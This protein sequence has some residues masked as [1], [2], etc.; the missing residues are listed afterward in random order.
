MAKLAMLKPMVA[1]L[2]T[3]IARPLP[4]QT[5][6]HYGTPEHK[7]WAADVIKR[8]GGVCRD[9]EHRGPRDGLRVVAD[10]VIER[11]D[12]PARQLDVSNGLTRCWACHTR[13]TA[14]ARAERAAAPTTARGGGASKV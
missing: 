8:D 7:R 2:D 4:K 1:T 9:P 14:R 10:H 6:P 3:S 12:D 13:K 11:K 5:D